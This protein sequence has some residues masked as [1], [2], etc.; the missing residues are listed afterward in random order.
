[1]F[2]HI[3]FVIYSKVSNIYS[4][5]IICLCN[6]NNEIMIIS[7]HCVVDNFR[8]LVYNNTYV[9]WKV[10]SYTKTHIHYQSSIKTY[11]VQ[12]LFEFLVKNEIICEDCCWPNIIYCPWSYD[13]LLIKKYAKTY[14]NALL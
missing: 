3:L 2:I 7:N 9:M 1:M 6:N 13:L 5:I 11:F 8:A 10:L 14:N 4:N 12:K